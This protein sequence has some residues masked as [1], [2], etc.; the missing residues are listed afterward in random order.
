MSRS[1]ILKLQKQLEAN[2]IPY[3]KIMEKLAP[4]QSLEELEAML[5]ANKELSDILE[6]IK[7]HFKEVRNLLLD[8]SGIPPAKELAQL[9]IGASSEALSSLREVYHHLEDFH[10]KLKDKRRP[11]TLSQDEL[12]FAEFGSL[13]AIRRSRYIINKIA[14]HLDE[15][16]ES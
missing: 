16:P 4:S 2:L 14:E 9:I 13:T 11:K 7:S 5:Q 6:S 1:K 10:S 3:E 15:V 12:H 8:T